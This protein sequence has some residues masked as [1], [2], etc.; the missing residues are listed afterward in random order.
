MAPITILVT[1]L[2]ATVYYP[3]CRRYIC[4]FEAPRNICGSDPRIDPKREVVEVKDR[5]KKKGT[6]SLKIISVALFST[7]L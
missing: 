1:K 7:D 6:S 4:S 3:E 2:S 5:I